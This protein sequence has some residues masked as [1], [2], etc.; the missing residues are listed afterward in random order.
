MGVELKRVFPRAL[1]R[2]GHCAVTAALLLGVGLLAPAAL[3]QEQVSTFFPDRDNNIYFADNLN[4]TPTFL[5]TPCTSG[6][7]ELCRSNGAGDAMAV[8]N[9]VTPS[10]IPI[11]RRGLIRFDLGSPETGSA[12]TAGAT[13]SAVSLRM[14]LTN[15]FSLG[16]LVALKQ[17]SEDWGEGTSDWR[18]ELVGGPGAGDSPT[19]GD[20]TWIHRFYDA[21]S[22]ET[23]SPWAF[24]GGT[25][26]PFQACGSAVEVAVS[27][28]ILPLEDYAPP[29]SSREMVKNVQQWVDVPSSN[30]GWLLEALGEPVSLSTR[31]AEPSKRPLLTV[32]FIPEPS[33]GLAGLAALATLAQL[34]RSRARR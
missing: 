11:D 26:V 2:A 16:G 17:L 19:T 25:C 8:S 12:I 13:I 4:Q 24:E 34:L 5:P 18:N 33:P 30:F 22:P 9:S 27:N 23:S 6:A 7:P 3:A 20:A 10:N 32:T 29:W 28:V 21:A 1:G 14:Y 31:E 15:V